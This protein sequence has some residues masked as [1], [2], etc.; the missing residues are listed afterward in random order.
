M[1][2]DFKLFA[3]A[4]NKD[5]SKIFCRLAYKKKTMAK[6]FYDFDKEKF[7]V[8]SYVKS[9]FVRGIGKNTVKK[10]LIEILRLDYDWEM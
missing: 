6:G 10:K 4:S 5:G 7:F 3:F 1:G 2:D 9:N 8:T